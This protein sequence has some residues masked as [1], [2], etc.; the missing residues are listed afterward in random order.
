VNQFKQISSII[1]YVD[2]KTKSHRMDNLFGDLKGAFAATFEMEGNSFV[3]TSIVGDT[4]GVIGFTNEETEKMMFMR[5]LGLTEENLSMLT[6]IMYEKAFV[7]KRNTLRHKKGHSVNTYG[8]IY[9]ITNTTLRELI[10]N[11]NEL[12]DLRL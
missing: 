7:F 6:K 9:R 10:I 4:E 8:I 12:I 11:E 2:S 3:V 5:Y 1:S